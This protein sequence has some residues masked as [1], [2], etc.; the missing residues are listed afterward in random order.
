MIDEQSQRVDTTIRLRPLS[1]RG[2][3]RLTCGKM[4]RVFFCMH[5]LVT[6]S[7]RVFRS[8]VIIP[9]SCLFF[10]GCKLFSCHSVCHT[11]WEAGFPAG[12][13]E[14]GP[15]LRF[16]GFLSVVSLSGVTLVI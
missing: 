3:H 7:V 15:A 5:I 10:N 6:L 9:A 13:G 4:L 14:G 16:S 11:C 8:Y 2:W 12:G 1:H